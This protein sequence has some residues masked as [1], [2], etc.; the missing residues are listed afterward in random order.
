MVPKG[1][2]ARDQFFSQYYLDFLAVLFVSQELVKNIGQHGSEGLIILGTIYMIFYK[3]KVGRA[4][5]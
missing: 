4:E 1:K 3:I 5:L 2:G